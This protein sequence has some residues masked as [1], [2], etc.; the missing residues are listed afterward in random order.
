[1]GID[2]VNAINVRIGSLES[3]ESEFIKIGNSVITCSLLCVPK[4]YTGR[5]TYIDTYGVHHDL[6]VQNGFTHLSETRH[7]PIDENNKRMGSDAGPES[8]LLNPNKSQ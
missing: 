5:I 3:R 7:P 6:P 2:K 1:M 4:D 8:F